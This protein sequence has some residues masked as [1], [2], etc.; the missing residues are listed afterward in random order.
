MCQN[1]LLL[2]KASRGEGAV[3]RY[4]NDGATVDEHLHKFTERAAVWA[5]TRSTR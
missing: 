2:D 1:P 4:A 5:G 3:R